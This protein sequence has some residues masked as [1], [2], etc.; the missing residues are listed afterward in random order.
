MDTP[1]LR[2][3]EGESFLNNVKPSTETTDEETSGESHVSQIP[4]TLKSKSI[5]KSVTNEIL[6]TREFKLTTKNEK[7]S[8]HASFLL[9]L[10]V[11][12]LGRLGNPC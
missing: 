9:E 1:C 11:S 7:R 5:H 10:A 12:V 4:N 3:P 2:W 6:F 8:V